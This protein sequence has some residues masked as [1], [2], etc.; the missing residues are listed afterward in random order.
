[1][2]ITEAPPTGMAWVPGGYEGNSP[3]GRPAR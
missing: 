2:L 3:A 1:M